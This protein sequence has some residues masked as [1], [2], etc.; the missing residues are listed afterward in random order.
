MYSKIL[1]F[2]L[3]LFISSLQA[4]SLKQGLVEFKAK[5]YK[6]A[7]SEWLP[8]GTN[9]D[10]QA[11]F[12]LSQIYE[13]GLGVE[14]NPAKAAQWLRLSAD[15]GLA[16][17]CYNL[18]NYYQLGFGVEND[19][20]K[21]VLWWHR[22]AFSGFAPA[23]YNLAGGYLYGQG[24]E[25]SI[26]Q[27]R[28]WYKKAADGGLEAA[29]ERL[30][31][32]QAEDV[33]IKT[34]S[35]SVAKKKKV[36]V[37]RSSIVVPMPEKEIPATIKSSKVNKDS[38]LI[39]TIEQKSVKSIS[40]EKKPVKP[41]TE[42]ETQNTKKSKPQQLTQIKILDQRNDKETQIDPVNQIVKS[43][44]KDIIKPAKPIKVVNKEKVKP[45][46]KKIV[47]IKPIPL[48]K[49]QI[50]LAKQD[51]KVIKKTKIVKKK[52]MVDKA[53]RKQVE[54]T[55][56]VKEKIT[57]QVTTKA[58]TVKV[59]PTHI[60]DTSWIKKQSPKS[61]T[62]QVMTT[63]D[64]VEAKRTIKELP[65]DTA[66]AMYQYKKDGRQMFAVIYGV[67]KDRMEGIKKLT[68]L[69]KHFP[70]RKPWLMRFTKPLQRLSN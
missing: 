57:Q 1:P 24:V 19:P 66:V 31:S 11:Q 16:V 41:A 30:L 12:Y 48:T 8:L 46:M 39:K 43:Q 35:A 22:A 52:V 18:G 29:K 21:T 64:F 40:T 60:K 2:V 7:L 70:H 68:E 47:I 65:D 26:K 51:K 14:K 50:K 6:T 38:T 28:Y 55:V 23:Q 20:S 69:S 4:A 37:R 34:A 42:I 33:V 15:Q 62:L 45:V 49:D 58:K 44:Q 56:V 25:K 61:F 36:A 27:A 17:A 63:H 67:F 10:V 3:L 13:K 9:G 32:I 53:V 5:N 59:K 54:E